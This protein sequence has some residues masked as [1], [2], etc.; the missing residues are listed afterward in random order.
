MDFI[1]PHGYKYVLFTFC[2]F[3]HWTEAF[4][5]REATAS[6]VVK[7]LLEKIILTQ[8]TPLELQSDR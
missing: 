7:V 2:M 4:P 3:P 6:S 1:Q 8:G 5:C